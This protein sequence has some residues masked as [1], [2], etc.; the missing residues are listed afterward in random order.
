MEPTQERAGGYKHHMKTEGAVI[1]V[2]QPGMRPLSMK[3]FEKAINVVLPVGR[4]LIPVGCEKAD[5][6]EKSA[7][8]FR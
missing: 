4:P 3:H 6:G 2:G 1:L 8:I 5:V 7:A